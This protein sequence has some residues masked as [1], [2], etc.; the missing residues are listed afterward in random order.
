[1]L[2][3]RTA[4][5]TELT[6]ATAVP[7]ANVRNSSRRP[8]IVL[9]RSIMSFTRT[10][11][12][13]DADSDNVGPHFGT[14]PLALAGLSRSCCKRFGNPATPESNVG[15]W[16]GDHR[17]TAYAQRLVRTGKTVS[18]LARRTEEIG[19]AKSS[20]WSPAGR[21]CRF[22][23]QMNGVARQKTLTGNCCDLRVAAPIAAGANQ[24]MGPANDD[25]LRRQLR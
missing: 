16:R 1:V 10:E 3:P 15:R 20:S 17:P 9:S 22:V 6:A 5:G 18:L 23:G 19:G 2:L 11:Q 4:N 25:L 8:S 24:R 21:T 12:E 13:K 14:R 7:A